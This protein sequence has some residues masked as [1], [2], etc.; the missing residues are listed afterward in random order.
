VTQSA[1]FA[2]LFLPVPAIMIEAVFETAVALRH[3][4]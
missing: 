4:E 2:G 1:F 3:N